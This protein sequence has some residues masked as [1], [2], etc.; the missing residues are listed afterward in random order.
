MGILRHAAG[1]TIT[2]SCY[3]RDG[4]DCAR[5]LNSRRRV[6][7]MPKSRL[8]LIALALSA[9]L[10]L[11]S[12]DSMPVAPEPTPPPPTATV[13]SDLL[14]G[15]LGTVQSLLLE[16]RP[17]S[18]AS[19]S[20]VIGP[21]G[22]VINV[23]PHSLVIPPGALSRNTTITAYAPSSRNNRV[24]FGPHGLRFNK[25]AYLTMSYANCYGL[26]M[27]L[28]KTI[29]YTDGGTRILEQLLSLDNIFTKRVTGRL[30][31]FSDYAIAWRSSRDEGDDQ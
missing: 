12:C 23:G 13:Q 30:E 11:V 22:G 9:A 21:L 7:A 6:F 10:V 24:Q 17:M 18:A 16:C 3:E 20:R 26:G 19:A 14:G 27:L 29:V 25:S 15:L 5:L 8:S 1:S 28:P 2:L 31:H 4:C